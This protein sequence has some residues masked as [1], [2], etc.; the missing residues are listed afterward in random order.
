MIGIPE[1][2]EYFL[3]SRRSKEG[4]GGVEVKDK[5]TQHTRLATW[6]EAKSMKPGSTRKSL[7]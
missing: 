2:P 3:R 6:S 5:V 1:K 4:E 7:K